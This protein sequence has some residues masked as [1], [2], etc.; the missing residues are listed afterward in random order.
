MTVFARRSEDLRRST[1]RQS[2]TSVLLAADRILSRNLS[3]RFLTLNQT[4]KNF[5]LQDLVLHHLAICFLLL[6]YS[7]MISSFGMSMFRLPDS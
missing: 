4:F 5:L 1:E 7:S 2:N 3:E 6:R